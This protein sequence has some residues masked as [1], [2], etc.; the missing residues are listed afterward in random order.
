MNRDVTMAYW[1]SHYSP[2]IDIQQCLVWLTDSSLRLGCEASCISCIWSRSIWKVNSLVRAL[3]LSEWG[4]HRD[5][6]EY[7]QSIGGWTGWTR[8]LSEGTARQLCRP[9]AV[10]GHT[11]LILFLL[12]LLRNNMPAR[13][14]SCTSWWTRYQDYV[15]MTRRW[16]VRYTEEGGI[17]RDSL[18]WP[19]FHVCRTSL[20]VSASRWI[21]SRSSLHYHWCCYRHGS[22][23]PTEWRQRIRANTTCLDGSQQSLQRTL[24]SL[25]EQSSQW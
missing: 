24:V 5:R 13:S 18:Q 7:W 17:R 2:M 10:S 25:R 22:G 1:W 19:P 11:T 14:T 16:T 9:R 4:E 23:D 21:R 12:Q 8:F 15:S 3:L 20:L 6:K